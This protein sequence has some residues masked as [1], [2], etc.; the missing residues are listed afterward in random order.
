MSDERTDHAAARLEVLPVEGIGE[1]RPGDD[2]VRAILDRAPALQDGDV[3][4]VTSKAVSKVEGR[5]IHLANPDPAGRDAARQAAIDAEAVRLVAQRGELKIVQT[6]Q[7]LVLA[8]A[9]VDE[10]NVAGDELALLPVDPDASA[11]ALRTGLRERLGVDVA[12]I[13]SDSLG[14]PWR[15]G[16][17]DQAIGVAGLQA[18]FDA[19]G[20]PDTHGR[21][22]LVTQV[23]VAD[24]IASAADLVKGKLSSVPVAIVRGL[25][26]DGK[27]VDDGLGT[28]TLLRGAADDLFRLGTTEAIDVGR[29]DAKG[30]TSTFPPLHHDAVEAIRGYQP[31]SLADASIREA[32]LGFLAARPDAMWRS[33]V[34]GHLTASAL[35]L[36][37]PSRSVLLTLHPRTGLWMQVG[38][39]C[40]PGDASLLDAARREAVEESGIVDLRFS[41][42]LLSLAVHP[43]ACSLGV[44]TRHFDVRFLAVNASAR[45]PVRSKES[46]DLRWFGW[47]ALPPGIAPELP[48]ELQLARSRLATAGSAE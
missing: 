35:I 4:V 38:G 32:F 3:L 41:P 30:A 7:G 42:Q 36:D 16:L 15:N 43:I 39:H 9:G 11:A 37:L 18:I 28:S 34:A 29:A 8:A 19:R 23:A 6:R 46:L 21:A 13:V 44:P 20:R 2:L 47:D 5:L 31:P 27:L 26:L 45:P 48:H 22:L 33:C 17:V 24:E 10:S 12:V 1:L 40:E 14:R 25:A